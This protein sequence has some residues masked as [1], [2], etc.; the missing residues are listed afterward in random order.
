MICSFCS[1]LC[2]EEDL[3]SVRCHV[4]S[5]GLRRIAELQLTRPTLVVDGHEESIQAASDLLR[6]AAHVLITGRISS[7]QT[8]RAAVG[9][10]TRLDATIDCAEGGHAFKNIAAIQRNG[11]HSVSIGE[12]RDQADL[13][14]VVGDDSVLANYPRLPHLLHPGLS[15]K[16]SSEAEKSGRSKKTVLLLGDFSEASQEVWKQTGF[17]A[18]YVPCA[19]EKVPSALM[20]WSSQA[21]SQGGNLQSLATD[22]SDTS[23]A[24]A[25]F[26]LMRCLEKARYTAVLWIASSL[27][28]PE[29]DLWIE[30]LLQ[31]IASQNET[32]RCA[33]LVLS[34][35]DGSFQQACTWLTGFPGRVRFR[36][37]VPHYDPCYNAYSQWIASAS[38]RVGESVIV[39]VDETVAK[40]PFLAVQSDGVSV[41]SD[42]DAAI[43]V[44]DVQA[45][46]CAFPC[47]VAGA[48][49][50]AVIFRADQVIAARV[51]PEWNMPS[52]E[53]TAGADP[54]G[55]DSH[56]FDSNASTINRERIPSAAAWLERLCR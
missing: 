36:Q 19:I 18:W 33:G 34:S 12:A 46:S 28:V 26:D 3:D 32:S 2:D 1:L 37:G 49:I 21:G 22:D 11:V 29:A 24:D 16:N 35:L 10:A 56:T 51:V 45:D 15:A 48:E 53:R 50:S 20:Q 27:T 4:R 13:L 55:A 42:G 9:L 52:L 47:A 25:S 5:E 14:I 30:R 23:V 6:S 41:Q 44:V 54:A 39:L 7:V 8:A 43:Q 17:D 38:D 40:P 31:W